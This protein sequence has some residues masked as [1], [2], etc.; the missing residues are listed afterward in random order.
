MNQSK[1]PTNSTSL[2]DPCLHELQKLL[3]ERLS[4]SNSV[5][6]QHGRDESFHAS[7]PPEAVSFAE[8]NEEVAEIVRTCV[9]H[10]KPIIPFGTGTSLEGHVAALQGG[11]CLDVSGM[12]QV[13]EVNENDLDCRV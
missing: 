5:R 2:K 1:S 6:E 9:Q 4:M 11:V 7:A 12:N 8:C 3:G 13:L 10:Q